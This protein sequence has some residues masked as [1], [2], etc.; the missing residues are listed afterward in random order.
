[1]TAENPGTGS[2]VE[3]APR[4]HRWARIALD[5]MLILAGAGL[6][7]V[8]INTLLIPN[9]IVAGGITGLALIAEL[10]LSIPISV[11]LLVLNLPLVV[12]QWRCLGGLGSVLRTIL[13]VVAL[14][15]LTEVTHG[16]VGPITEDRL[17]VVVYGGVL[18]GVGLALVFLGRGTTGGGDIL[19][20]LFFQFFG[21]GIGR[22][23]L[24]VNVLV[25]GLAAW[26]FGL[27]PAMLALLLSYVMSHT[28]D[29]VLHGMTSNRVVWVVSRHPER[30]STS[31]TRELGRGVTTLPGRGG[32]TGT[33][34][35]FLYIV[36][37]RSGVQRLKREI[38]RTD[39]DAF[40]TIMSPRE[41]IGGFQ[42]TTP[43]G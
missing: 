30:V 35:G 42:S 22:T 24:G 11:A 2:P 18:S 32:H 36:V 29:A 23:M 26:L 16:V 4:S 7:A 19:G 1:M 37:P 3:Q 38:T 25:Y 12:L 28:L 13:G 43:M 33:E 20:R 21:W 17:L 8:A 10:Q 31:I 15:L 9:E 39:P 5:I 14:A 27:E 40:I 34:V 41:S 6:N